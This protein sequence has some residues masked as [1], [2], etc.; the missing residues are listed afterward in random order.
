MSTWNADDCVEWTYERQE[1]DIVV[2]ARTALEA[3][4]TIKQHGFLSVNMKKLKQT[5]GSISRHLKREE[6][7]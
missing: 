2:F 6:I 1:G 4:E 3:V 7:K 5:G